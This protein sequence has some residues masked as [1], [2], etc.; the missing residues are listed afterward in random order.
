MDKK[1]GKIKKKIEK[2]AKNKGLNEIKQLKS[3]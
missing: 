2:Q 1:H 3:S